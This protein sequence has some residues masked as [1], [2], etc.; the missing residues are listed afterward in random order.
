MT[1]SSMAGY[2]LRISDDYTALYAWHTYDDEGLAHFAVQDGHGEIVAR[3][4]LRRGADGLEAWD[5]WCELDSE[6]EDALMAH[7]GIDG[8]PH[9]SGIRLDRCAIRASILRAC[10]DAAPVH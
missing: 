10:L 7:G 8:A 3:V 6:V 1:N 5:G 4:A 2:L 9:P